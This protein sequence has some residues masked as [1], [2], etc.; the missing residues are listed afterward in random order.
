MQRRLDAAQ[1]IVP[2]FGFDPQC[3]MKQPAIE[4]A[5]TQWLALGR[6]YFEDNLGGQLTVAQM[7]E[8]PSGSNDDGPDAIRMGLSLIGELLGNAV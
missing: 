1:C 7:K 3:A 8:F 2:L 4:E 5:L 6:I